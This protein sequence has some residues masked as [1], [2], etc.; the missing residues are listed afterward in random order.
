MK[1]AL[2]PARR[3]L[4]AK[5]IPPNLSVSAHRSRAKLAAVTPFRINTCESVSKQKT[6]TIFR[7]NTYAKQG[8]GGVIVN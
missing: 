4:G 6:L 7:M 1:L 3:N 2:Q 8:E 5:P